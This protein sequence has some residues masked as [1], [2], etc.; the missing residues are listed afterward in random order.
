MLKLHHLAI[1]CVSL[2]AARCLKKFDCSNLGCKIYN[3]FNGVVRQKAPY[4]TIAHAIQNAPAMWAVNIEEEV[5][6][7]EVLS[8]VKAM[9]HHHHHWNAQ[10][11]KDEAAASSFFIA[12][13]DFLHSPPAP[14]SSPFSHQTRETFTLATLPKGFM[15]HRA[16]LT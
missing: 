10:T 2:L 12:D 7:E 15:F 5:G 14:V 6:R 3:H 16:L 11:A 9:E 4:K 1:R 13:F 8:R